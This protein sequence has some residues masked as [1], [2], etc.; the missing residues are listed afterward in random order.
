MQQPSRAMREPWR[1]SLAPPRSE[2]DIIHAA[3]LLHEIGKFT[4]PDRILH[5]EAIEDKD[6]SIVK[7][8]P[9][10]GAILV[11]A[12]DGYGPAADAILYHHE[13]IDGRG[14]PA[15]LI[16]NEIPLTSR[17]LAICCTYHTMIAG[18]GYRSPMTAAEATEELANAARNGQLDG[19][20]VE[21]FIAVLEREGPALAEDA[22]FEIELEFERR[23]Q[24]MAEP[25]SADPLS[26]SSS[27]R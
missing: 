25:R 18:Q 15:G 9:R 3:G 19:E 22:D 23:V 8:H 12:L 10:E 7:D 11:G 17:V 2:L 20:L 26:R 27:S 1:R 5:A 4:W 14:Y 16:G 6:L 13:R 24:E 21:H